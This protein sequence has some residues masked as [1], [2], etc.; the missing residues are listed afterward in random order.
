MAG[1]SGGAVGRSATGRERLAR[2]AGCVGGVAHHRAHGRRASDRRERKTERRTS[3]SRPEGNAARL[4]AAVR[5]HWAIENRL[6]WVLDLAFRED[7]S[8][9]RARH[10]AENLAV[11]R[12]IALNLLRQETTAQVG[13]PTRRLMAGW[14]DAVLLTVLG[15]R[16]AI[17][18]VSSRLIRADQSALLGPQGRL[19]SATLYTFNRALRGARIKVR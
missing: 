1:S 16:D 19:A 14:D 17:A 8:R 2:P 10:A 13:I 18:L 5:S 4:L 6:H 7:E 3:L 9:V 11:I 15:L 12:H